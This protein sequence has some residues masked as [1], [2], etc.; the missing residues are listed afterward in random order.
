MYF[1]SGIPSRYWQH[2]TGFQEWG[3]GGQGGEK[4]A[5]SFTRKYMF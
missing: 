4:K 5:L 2:I 3:G 1:L